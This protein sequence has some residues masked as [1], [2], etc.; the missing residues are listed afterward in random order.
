PSLPPSAGCGRAAPRVRR[1]EGHPRG[2]TRLRGAQRLAASRLGAPGAGSGP[3]R[4]RVPRLLH[5]PGG[6]VASRRPPARHPARRGAAGHG[7]RR[8]RRDRRRGTAG[9][10]AP[11]GG[12]RRQERGEGVP[13]PWRM[14]AAASAVA[15]APGAQVIAEISFFGAL[16][17]IA[18]VYIGYPVVLGVVAMMRRRPVR[19]RAIE[20]PVSLIICAY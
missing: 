6:L 7:L 12:R 4:T 3:G 5:Q 1:V 11:D 13:R 2:T 15:G 18:W 9:P 20:P 10:L 8:L 14:A 17:V 19:R 16:G